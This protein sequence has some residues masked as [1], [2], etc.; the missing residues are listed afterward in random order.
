MTTLGNTV[1]NE[2]DKVPTSW[3]EWRLTVNICMNKRFK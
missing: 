3:S 1:E 2:G